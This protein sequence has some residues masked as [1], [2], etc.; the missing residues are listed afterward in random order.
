MNRTVTRNSKDKNKGKDILRNK[1]EPEPEFDQNNER[2]EPID[3]P[4]ETEPQEENNNNQRSQNTEARPIP[5]Y[6]HRQNSDNTEDEI[7]ITPRD[8]EQDSIT[9]E[10]DSTL[11]APNSSMTTDHEETHRE[12]PNTEQE[13]EP[14]QKTATKRKRSKINYN[15]LHTGKTSGKKNKPSE[16]RTKG[17]DSPDHLKRQL[18]EAKKENK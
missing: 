1:P 2:K 14:Q 12:Q 6:N 8:S 13:H 16:K 17:K 4:S 10:V 5:S 7:E 18:K 15:Q 11:D 9:S 3:Q